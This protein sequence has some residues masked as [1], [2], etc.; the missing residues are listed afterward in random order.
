MKCGHIL[1]HCF[2]C[3]TAEI[4]NH[5]H[6][7]LLGARRERPSGRTDKR[8]ELASFQLTELH[9][10]PQPGFSQ[11]N[12]LPRIKGLAA[13]R[14]FDQTDD[15]CGSDSVLRRPQVNVRIAPESGTSDLR[16]NAY[17]P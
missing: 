10:L 7:W 3:C 14:H 2:K 5:W 11:H 1:V 16:V 6:R 4:P 9:S 17:T 15:R 12:G 8:D 13:V